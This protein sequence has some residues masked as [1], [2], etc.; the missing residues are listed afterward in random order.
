MAARRAQ[1]AKRLLGTAVG[2]GFALLGAYTLVGGRGLPDPAGRL[3]WYG[4]T[5]LVAGVTAI[6]ASWWAADVDRVWCRHP[7]RRWR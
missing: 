3:H 4:V 6:V 1:L 2:A 7:P 5:L